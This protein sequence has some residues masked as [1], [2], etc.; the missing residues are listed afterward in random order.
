MI[1][2]TLLIVLFATATWAQTNAPFT[3]GAP[4]SGMAGAGPTQTSPITVSLQDAIR[5]AQ[6]NASQFRTAV[7]A[8]GL[9]HQD[10]VQARAALLPSLSYATGAILTQPNG[11]PSGVF[12]ANNGPNEYISWGTAHQAL[13][14]ATVADYQRSRAL[15]A[16]ARANLEIARRGLVTTVVTAYYGVI[17]ARD[18]MQNAQ[19]A[20]DEAQRFLKLTRQLERGGE[21]AHSDVVKAQLQAND[22]EVAVE[23]ARVATEAA[24][25]GLA[26]LIFPNFTENFDVVND[27]DQTPT[28]PAFD[29]AYALAARNNP[30]IAAATQ[31]LQAAQHE[32]TSTIGDRLP[33]LTV[34]YFYGID[35]NHYAVRTDHINN[36]GYS[37]VATLNLPV[38]DWGALR[39]KTK[40]AQLQRDL[41][42]V[43]LS[44][45]QRAALANLRIFYHAAETARGQLG[46]LKQSVDLAAEG[47]R[48]TTLRYQGGEATALEVV[49]AQNALVLARNNYD[50]GA[51]RYRT[52]IAQLQTL[53]GTF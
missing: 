19:A 26:V 4:V 13:S 6:A 35:A 32:V 37:V 51:A 30:E 8:A 10:T 23:N 39:S 14:L 5:L 17:V 48:L 45:T 9:A 44:E 31:A 41:A 1:W 53:T 29:Q 11:T 49:D 7:T 52:A 2:K 28:L 18:K 38:F 33:S 16:V 22:A 40:Q 21:V 15:E 43:Q 12:I 25:L 20:A 42:R 47:L 27:L 3:P 50:D 24:K 46:I 34:D 36:L